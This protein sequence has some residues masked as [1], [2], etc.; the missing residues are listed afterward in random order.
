MLSTDI[1]VKVASRCNINC[2]YCY[3]YNLG[4]DS[5]LDQPKLMSEEV[6]E[7]LV[8]RVVEAEPDE[9][10]TLVFHGGEPLIVGPARLARYAQIARAALGRRIGLSVQTN[11]LLVTPEFVDVFASY[12]IAVGVSIDGSR[13]VHDTS[14]VDFMGRGTFDRALAGVRLLVDAE[15]RG[16]VR[17]GGA[18]C[19][20]DPAIDADEFFAL[21]RLLRLQRF[22]VLLPDADH[23]NRRRYYKFADDELSTWLKRMFKI[24]WDDGMKPSIPLFEGILLRMYGAS[25]RTE[26][27]GGTSA[28]SIIVETNGD[29]T[30]HDVLRINRSALERKS[31]VL[32]DALTSILTSPL[33]QV[34][35]SKVLYGNCRRCPVRKICNGGFVGHRYSV[36]RGYENESVWCEVLQDLIG[37]VYGTVARTHDAALRRRA[38]AS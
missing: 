17:F 20:A 5:Y 15:S 11:G 38:T 30:S 28:P 23:E 10:S 25:S 8:Q 3:M 26:A 37:Y 9:N 14:R 22:S 7:A 21:A 32:T 35:T 19:V 13:A 12:D 27:L 1:I 2:T 24:W 31:N 18:I 34:A 4:D 16:L 33:Y 6:F 36:A 29:I